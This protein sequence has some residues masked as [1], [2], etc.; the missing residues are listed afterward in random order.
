MPQ[1]GETH[2][3]HALYS[4]FQRL[5]AT[6]SSEACL[7]RI[8]RDQNSFKLREPSSTQQLLEHPPIWIYASGINPSACD[9]VTF[10]IRYGEVDGENQGGESGWC[11]DNDAS[12]E[13]DGL[14]AGV[15][16]A[17]HKAV[18]GNEGKAEG[19]EGSEETV[20]GH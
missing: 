18:R 15:Q 6:T 14:A 3:E 8:P 17:W 10:A 2:S 12:E 1:D 9:R 19:E 20:M 11:R 13:L 7:S 4:R 5:Q 16:V